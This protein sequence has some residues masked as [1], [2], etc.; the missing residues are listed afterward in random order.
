[1]DVELAISDS[2]VRAFR[3]PVDDGGALTKP[4][5]GASGERAFADPG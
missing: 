3:Q 5:K 4:W 2:R 1:M